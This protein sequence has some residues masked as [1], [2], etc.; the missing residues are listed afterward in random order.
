MSYQDGGIVVFCLGPIDDMLYCDVVHRHVPVILLYLIEQRLR[1]HLERYYIRVVWNF[2]SFYFVDGC[3]FLLNP[4]HCVDVRHTSCQFSSICFLSFSN[5]SNQCSKFRS[6]NWL[7]FFSN[8]KYL[9][10]NFELGIVVYKIVIYI[11][12]VYQKYVNHFF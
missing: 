11:C 6:I 12:R 4:I 2:I 10:I 7:L 8:I 5:T 1:L 3:V 9:K